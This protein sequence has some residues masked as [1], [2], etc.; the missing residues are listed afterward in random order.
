MTT[1]RLPRAL[2][3]VSKYSFHFFWFE[4][5]IFRA[6]QKSDHRPSKIPSGCDRGISAANISQP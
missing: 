1:S 2:P 4:A 3:N 6:R 5:Q